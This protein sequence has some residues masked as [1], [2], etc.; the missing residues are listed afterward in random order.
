MAGDFDREQ[1][2]KEKIISDLTE[3]EKSIS[4]LQKSLESKGVN[5]HRL[6][7]TGYLKALVD[8]GL[9]KEKEI[10][11]AR[12]YFPLYHESKDIYDYTGRI[13]RLYDEDSSG[14]NVLMILYTLFS[15]PIFMREIERCN[16]DLPRSYRKVSSQKRLDYIKKLEETGIKIPQ[17]NMMIEPT[18]RDVSQL[19]HFMRELVISV[20]DLKRYTLPE[21]STQK[22]LD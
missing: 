14:D 7:L 11:P 3:G 18:H 15:R 16:V 20:F 12:I 6:Y 1:N 9:L 13:S 19:V 5:H 4:G 21:E 8:I 22:T 17:N 2:L 10:K